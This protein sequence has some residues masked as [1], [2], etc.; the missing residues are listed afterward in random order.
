VALYLGYVSARLLANGDAL[1]A[2]RHADE[3]LHLERWLHLDVEAGTNAFFSSSVWL[4]APVSYWYAARMR[5]RSHAGGTRGRV[6]D[7]VADVSHLW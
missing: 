4:A 3:I 1:A 7:D 5:S 2:R 6:R